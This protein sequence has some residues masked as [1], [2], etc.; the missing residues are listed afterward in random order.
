MAFNILFFFFLTHFFRFALHRF[1][2]LY[3]N[4][5]DHKNVRISA[6]CPWDT[7]RVAGLQ[8]TTEGAGHFTE[9]AAFFF[10]ISSTHMNNH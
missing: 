4:L 6:G 10:L 2:R 7:E 5:F 3:S 8:L 9:V 1:S